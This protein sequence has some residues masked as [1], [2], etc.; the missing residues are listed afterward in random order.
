[1]H[2]EKEVSKP[3]DISEEIKKYL[4][5]KLDA[6]AMHDLERRAQDD[7]FLMDALEGYEK[8][9]DVGDAHLKDLSEKLRYRIEQK[10]RR[11]IPWRTMGIAAS[12]LLLL[13]IGLFWYLDRKPVEQQKEKMVAVT[14]HPVIRYAPPMPDTMQ[15][16]KMYVGGGEPV[17]QKSLQN[18]KTRENKVA[19]LA[20]AKTRHRRIATVKYAPPAVAELAVTSPNAAAANT[21]K[22]T[23]TPLNEMIVTEYSA[24]KKKEAA[25]ALKKVPGVAADTTTRVLGKNIAGIVKAEGIPLQGTIVKIEGTDLATLTDNQGR[26]RFSGVPDKTAT[27]ELS[28]QGYLAQQLYNVKSD[29]L[30]IAM[31]PVASNLN[32]VV[33]VGYGTQRKAAITGG[34]AP[35]K[36]SGGQ[37]VKGV[38][39]DS[40]SPIPGATV[41]VRGTNKATVTDANG[42]FTLY[43]VPDGAVI[44]VKFIGYTSQD[45]PV[46][47][48]SKMAITMYPN[49]SAL[50]EVVTVPADNSEDH[51][52]PYPVNGWDNY[53]Y[54][55]KQKAISPD[56]KKGT[57]RLSFM[58]DQYNSISDIKVLKSVS[59]QTDSLAVSL[60]KNGPRW[61]VGTG[62]RHKVKLSIKFKPQ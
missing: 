33:V 30:Q 29:S 34:A 6:R 41:M 59:P 9:G 53:N 8:T 3:G 62:D 10:E 4:T 19:M 16:D 5:G 61:N 18:A 14:S 46:T 51:F 45:L 28:H 24:M 42:A 15:R 36:A 20:P 44:S 31:Q 58:V 49:T 50:A 25:D 40:A 38:V 32:E 12:I 56:G 17:Q 27:L 22:D 26:F 43:N 2:G 23:T 1:L 13:G 54:Y 48:D 39:R 57:V 35:A 60:V 11:I 21:D 37:V 7:P 47:K 55:L 52:M